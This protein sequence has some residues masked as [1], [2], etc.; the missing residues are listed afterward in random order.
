[1]RR[2]VFPTVLALT[3]AATPV[4][5]VNP[6]EV[7]ADPALEE[8][9]RN[10]SADLRCVV[11]RGENIDESN[12]AIARDLRLLV[13]ERLVEGDS[14]G[15]V[16]D[17]IVERYGEYVL[18]KPNSSGANVVLWAA[19]PALFIAALIAGGLYLRRRSQA[20]ETASALSTDEEAR[21]KEL[22]KD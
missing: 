15:E 12:A 1:M 20:N 11:C 17:F 4:F 7:L 6:D 10:I 22:L 21:L 9:A 18:M 13:R 2:F 19:G 5:A 3:L 8:R 16:V 14:N